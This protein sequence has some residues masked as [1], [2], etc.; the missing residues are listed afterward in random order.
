MMK[1]EYGSVKRVEDI[2]FGE[3]SFDL[4]HASTSA[5]HVTTLQRKVAFG[6]SVGA[7]ILLVTLTSRMSGDI[8]ATENKS[9][10]KSATASLVPQSSDEQT[11][12]I[13]TISEAMEIP[14]LM[15]SS[16]ATH[17]EDLAADQEMDRKSASKS[18]SSKSSDPSDSTDNDS[19]TDSESITVVSDAADGWS[20]GRTWGWWSSNSTKPEPVF[21]SSAITKLLLESLH[22]LNKI[23]SVGFG[24]QYS[25]YQGQNWPWFQYW[26]KYDK[27]DVY[28]D[29]QDY[30]L[31]FGYDLQDYFKG[32][33][34]GEYIKWAGQ[35][36]AVVSFSWL[37]DN[38]ATGG[39]AY[40][41]SC[42]DMNLLE[43]VMPGGKLH[44]TWVG[45]L[46]TLS[47]F[48]DTLTFVNGEKIPFVFRLFHEGT[49][50][51]YWWGTKCNTNTSFVG[52][53]NYTAHYLQDV[54]GHR[55][56]IWE[57]A[58]SKPSQMTEEFEDF[59]PGDDLIDVISFDRYAKND[60]YDKYLVSDCTTVV[61]FAKI[62]NK[63]AVLAE[64]GI[65]LG[66]QN[67]SQSNWYMK[68]LLKPLMQ[69]CPTLAY[70][71]TYTDFN[72][73]NYWVPLKGQK[74]YQGFMD[75]YNDEH[76]VFLNDS[77]WK[78]LKYYK[79]VD[80]MTNI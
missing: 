76:S 6:F 78:G 68:R 10:L 20:L 41:N 59:Y 24:H 71:L 28:N 1:Q 79:Y 36:G 29:T 72:S 43:E 42:A 69:H 80:E 40:N 11:S 60:T 21:N 51:W 8:T 57:Y 2:T 35:H 54:K 23:N 63:V 15:K 66:I 19:G 14:S 77:L 74:T 67:I 48:F 4:E 34:Y 32:H 13:S 52:A 38:P 56:I 61:D 70:A 27:S 64:T 16:G 17:T 30:P 37:A 5:K 3:R 44:E 50:W 62:H 31:V 75:F 53:W 47:D 55:N 39:D 22:E 45:W 25:N 49:A 18:S 7:V 33:A 46:D 65:W 12:V 73:G 9:F 58:P 26:G